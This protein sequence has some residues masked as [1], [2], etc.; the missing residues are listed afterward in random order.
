MVPTVV[1]H[2]AYS[3]CAWCLHTVVVHGDYRGCVHGAWQVHGVYVVVHGAVWPQ[4]EVHERYLRKI[5]QYRAVLG[6]MEA[7]SRNEKHVHSSIIFRYSIRA[8]LSHQ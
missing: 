1:V 7:I 8:A 5:P 2:G 3:G 6:S 4:M